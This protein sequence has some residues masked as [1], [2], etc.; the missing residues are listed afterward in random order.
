[1]TVAAVSRSSRSDVRPGDLL[2]AADGVVTVW[3]GFK[4]AVEYMRRPKRRDAVT[5]VLWRPG[6]AVFH[7]GGAA[8]NFVD[9]FARRVTVMSQETHQKRRKE[10]SI[11]VVSAT[12]RPRPPVERNCERRVDKLSSD[13][14]DL[15][16]GSR[17][18]E[19]LDP[20][21]TQDF[22]SWLKQ[23]KSSWR[24]SYSWTLSNLKK[25]EEATQ[26]V[27]HLPE[28]TVGSKDEYDRVEQ[29]RRWLIIRKQQWRVER[30]RRKRKLERRLRRR[31][32]GEANRGG[33]ASGCGHGRD[34]T[35][36]EP[37]DTSETDSAGTESDTEQQLEE[38]GTTQDHGSPGQETSAAPQHEIIDAML[39]EQERRA[40]A[41]RQAR[42]T[43]KI[44][45]RFLFDPEKGASDDIC[46]HIFC[47]LPYEEHGKLLCVAAEL[48]EGLKSR[49]EMW[50]VLCPQRWRLPRRPRK[51]WHLLYLSKR[52]EE[53]QEVRELSD[54]VLESV[55]QILQKGDCLD[56]IKKIL[57]T[58]EKKFQ[59]NLNYTSGVLCERNS[60]LNLAVIC[61]RHK[62]SKWLI[63]TKGADIATTDRG[64]F[65]P[66]LNAAWNGDRYLA[67]F[68]LSRGANRID[69]GTSHSSCP[70]A[71]SNFEGMTA[72]GWARKW[73]FL[74]VADLIKLGYR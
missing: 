13:F 28:V 54:R 2:V 26:T 46:A 56:K 17:L 68:L 30:R 63:D 40:L 74:E 5:V 70:L 6:R 73:G 39:E 19:F 49:G 67:K 21:C 60:I 4:A 52:R 8:W 3:W 71:P 24:R 44:D 65:T 38:M 27:V 58:S 42:K 57:A 43:S 31:R 34:R 20:H 12:K 18:G 16:D 1:M 35:E 48:S 37:T 64:G 32:N 7:D 53:I 69:V 72:E 22:M 36:K 11:P 45:I 66:L 61:R 33:V 10:K 14:V 29:Y 9:S 51:P 50:R 41:D 47:Y 59:F 15:D 23:R 55:H 62:C 25:I